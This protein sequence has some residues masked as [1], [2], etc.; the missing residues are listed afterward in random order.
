MSRK[1][2]LSLKDSNKDLRN[3]RGPNGYRL[4]RF[5]GREVLPPRRTFCSDKC[6]HEWKLRSDPG[7]LREQVY[8]R[9]L[10][11]CADCGAD[12]RYQRIQLED[13]LRE[14]GYNERDERYK[15]LL[16]T[17]NITILEARKSLWQA[18]HVVAVAAG[19]GLCD[20]T[21]IQTLCTKCHK[22]KT[23]R[24]ASAGAKPRKLKPLKPQ[25]LK[26]LPGLKG[27]SGKIED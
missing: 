25:G 7:Y 10:G 17:L 27:F 20:L 19:G 22:R 24:A 14:C 5:C 23:G 11:K 16:L 13:T 6:V 26:G 2:R 12:T 3:V 8:K 9:D 1:R 15:A 21:N 18:D 4:C